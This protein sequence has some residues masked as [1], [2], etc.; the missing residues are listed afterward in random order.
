MQVVVSF[1]MR[2]MLVLTVLPQGVT[3]FGDL[4][5][6]VNGRV[7]LV[8]MAP[9]ARR[10]PHLPAVD[11]LR[12]LPPARVLHVVSHQRLQAPEHHFYHFT[13]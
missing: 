4:P 13:C 8:I 7:G 5:C 1:S 11:A 2:H 6:G 10:A 3:R 9:T 12:V